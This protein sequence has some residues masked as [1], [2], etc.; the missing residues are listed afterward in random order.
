[1][2]ALYWQLCVNTMYAAYGAWSLLVH[3]DPAFI[4]DH[5][6]IYLNWGSL[7][8]QFLAGCRW[9]VTVFTDVKL[10]H[11]LDLSGTETNVHPFI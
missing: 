6:S 3:M 1:M 8:L 7:L 5:T 10:K 2:S 4:R 11:N 9:Q